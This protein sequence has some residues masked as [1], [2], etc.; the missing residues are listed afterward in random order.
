MEAWGRHMMTLPLVR[1]GRLDEATASARGALS[2]FDE[3]GDLSGVAMVLRYL[4]G[5][6]ILAGDNRKAGVLY[7]AAEK[8]LVSTGAGLTAY[9]EDVFLERDPTEILP[10][11][12]LARL[13]KEGAAMP[14]AKIVA[15]AMEDGTPVS[16]APG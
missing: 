12:D 3:A 8:L 5:L 10:K 11:A 15:Y 6:A 7:G 2:H 9:I 1:L 4:S 16:Q 14:L 13:S